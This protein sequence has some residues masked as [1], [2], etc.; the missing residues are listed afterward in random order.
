[1]TRLRRRPGAGYR[2]YSEDDYLTGVDT[3]ADWGALPAV[4]T[5]RGRRL[6]RLA[7]AAA[8]AGAVGT[9][10][11]VIGLAGLRAH[12]GARRQI[13]EHRMPPVRMAMPLRSV[14][15][16]RVTRRR[17]VTHLDRPRRVRAGARP[18]RAAH[19]RT[20]QIEARPVPEV[21]ARAVVAAR[22]VMASAA[23]DTPAVVEARET[24]PAA[25]ARRAQ[26][27]FGFER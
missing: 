10:G 14:S 1:M 5:M 21:P 7:G 23:R 3:L 12:S 24:S 16:A 11:G 2:V 22:T 15:S 20:P 4:E 17:R 13:A 27:E 8:L 18:V 19:A 26:S 9:V 25:E 6:S